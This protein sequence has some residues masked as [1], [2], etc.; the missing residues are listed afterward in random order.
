MSINTPSDATYHWYDCLATAGMES[1]QCMMMPIRS[2]YVD[3]PSIKM[4]CLAECRLSLVKCDWKRGKIAK[5]MRA[6]KHIHGNCV[7]RLGAK[8][9]GDGM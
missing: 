2:L 9:T 7:G 6:P 4:S 3:S 1:H 5:M 8:K